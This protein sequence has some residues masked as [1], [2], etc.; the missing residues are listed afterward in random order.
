[1]GELYVQKCRRSINMTYM[2]R[3]LASEGYCASLNEIPCQ[4]GGASRKRWHLPR[5]YGSVNK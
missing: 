1:M 4:V 3:K 2:R 5:E